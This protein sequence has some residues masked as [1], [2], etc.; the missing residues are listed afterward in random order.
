MPMRLGC[1]LWELLVGTSSKFRA[2]GVEGL[3]WDPFFFF[4]WGGVL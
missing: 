2:S 3:V 4:F 1:K